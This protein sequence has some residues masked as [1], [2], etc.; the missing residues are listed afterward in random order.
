VYDSKVSEIFGSHTVIVCHVVLSSNLPSAFLA[1][2]FV[3]KD[4]LANLSP[5]LVVLIS[6]LSPRLP[7]RLLY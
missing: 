2:L 6:G 4:S 7:T 1:F 5:F 3:A